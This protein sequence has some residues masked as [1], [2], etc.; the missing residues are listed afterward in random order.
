MH[1]RVS[2][3]LRFA[4]HNNSMKSMRALA[5]S[6]LA[7]CALHNSSRLHAPCLGYARCL[8]LHRADRLAHLAL[9]LL[10]PRH[11]SLC[12][13]EAC[14][15]VQDI[16]HTFALQ[17]LRVC[18]SLH[19]CLPDDAPDSDL[20]GRSLLLYVVLDAQVNTAPKLVLLDVG[21]VAELTPEDQQNLVGFFKVCSC[22]TACNILNLY[23]NAQSL[24]GLCLCKSACRC[25]PCVLI[26]AS[27]AITSS[28]K[29]Q[30]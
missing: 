2:F 9:P 13:L 27:K 21:M 4:M 8:W 16:N 26:L 17:A 15:N 24:A 3:A 20:T 19:A 1:S 23:V 6:R 11:A 10:A 5:C 25:L 12:L 29:C 22:Q 28:S 7:T 18:L 14:K 30:P